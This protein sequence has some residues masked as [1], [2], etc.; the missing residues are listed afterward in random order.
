M[1][2]FHMA[3][4]IRFGQRNSTVDIETKKFTEQKSISILESLL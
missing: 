4:K 2:R 1:L 3:R